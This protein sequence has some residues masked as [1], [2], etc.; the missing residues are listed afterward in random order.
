MEFTRERNNLYDSVINEIE[1]LNDYEKMFMNI[2][3]EDGILVNDYNRN[4]DLIRFIQL[5]SYD[6]FTDKMFRAFVN[7]EHAVNR[8]YKSVMKELQSDKT[9]RAIYTKEIFFDLYKE[10]NRILNISNYGRLYSKD[11][12]SYLKNYSFMG[13]SEKADKDICKII[14]S[15]SEDKRETTTT[16]VLSEATDRCYLLIR[17]FFSVMRAQMESKPYYN[18]S[19]TIMKHVF[20]I[21]TM[22]SVV[23]TT[24][25]IE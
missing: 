4:Y 14:E 9:A 25:K 6:I 16:E 13:Y 18:Q 7:I 11:E 10:I 2:P 23:A 1:K 8:M 15:Y 24:V 3:I 21:T 17:K 19:T 20:Y 12:T 22:I 5:K